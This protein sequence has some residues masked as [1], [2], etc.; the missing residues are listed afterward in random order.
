MKFPDSYKGIKRIYLAEILMLIVVIMTMVD[1]I[2]VAANG[3]VVDNTLI[4]SEGT[5][6][7]VSVL[8]IASGVLAII[9]FVLNLIG[10]INCRKDDENFRIALFA[11][12][13]G[14]VLS[15]VQAVTNKSNSTVSDW[16]NTLTSIANLFASYFVLTGCANLAE[17]YPDGATKNVCL[18]ARNLLCGSFALSALLKCITSLTG[19][20]ATNS[21][22]WT[23]LAVLATVVE[24]AS[25]V[26]YMTALA[27]SK[28]MLAR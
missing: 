26:I 12:L 23:I 5:L 7:F 3:V 20:A 1:V 4:V 28:R 19:I 22:L 13:A 9:A 21:V 17:T 16:M 18:K 6:T 24:I 14:I 25:Y 15:V 11:T 10:G 8:T 27:R 2:T